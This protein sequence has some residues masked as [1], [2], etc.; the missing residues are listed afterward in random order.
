MAISDQFH[1]DHSK[2]THKNY[3]GLIIVSY[4]VLAVVFLISLYAASTAPGTAI[5]DFASMSVFP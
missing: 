5:G 4:A 3:D 2:T 1:L